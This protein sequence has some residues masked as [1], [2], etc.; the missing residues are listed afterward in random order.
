MDACG[1]EIG[2]FFFLKKNILS[3]KVCSWQ[4]YGCKIICR[5]IKRNAA[6]NQ[7]LHIEKIAQ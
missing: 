6:C 5:F 3:Q 4:I 7:E 1:L 2:D